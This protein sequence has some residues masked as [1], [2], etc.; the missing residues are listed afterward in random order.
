MRNVTLSM[1]A[2]GV[3][4]GGY[5]LYPDKNEEDVAKETSRPNK[6]GERFQ[7]ARGSGGTLMAEG[8]PSKSIHKPGCGCDS[9]AHGGVDK[10]RTTRESAT[11]VV[12]TPELRVRV[13]NHAKGQRVEFALPGGGV[14][15]G[16][17]EMT[18]DENGRRVAIQG[19]LSAP[20]KGRFFFQEQTTLEGA[21]SMFGAVHFDDG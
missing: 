10:A 3:G 2:L 18:H 19:T 6:K 20:Q 21:E 13:L 8:E 1:L 17:V 5:L 15:V 4:I 14:A 9:H 12:Y 7:D 16:L 11:P